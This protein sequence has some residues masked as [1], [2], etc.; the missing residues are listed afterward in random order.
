MEPWTV[1]PRCRA[2]KSRDRV[3]RKWR[4]GDNYWSS[5]TSI[6][7]VVFNTHAWRMRWPGWFCIQM[8]LKP[9]MTDIEFCPVIHCKHVKFPIK[10][11]IDYVRPLCQ[12]DVVTG[13]NTVDRLPT[14]HTSRPAWLFSLASSCQPFPSTTLTGHNRILLG[15]PCVFWSILDSQ[16]NILRVL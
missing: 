4:V 13:A 12:L 1:R 2:G 6:V 16:D 5:D 14:S 11:D 15:R 10:S 3:G 8:W 9:E 7:A